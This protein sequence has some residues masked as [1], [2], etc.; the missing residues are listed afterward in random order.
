MGRPLRIRIH[1]G[2]YVLQ[3]MFNLIDRFAEQQV[4][5]NVAFQLFCSY[6][7]IKKWHAPDHTKIEAFRSRLSL[8]TQSVLLI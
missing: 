5:D 7:F 6:G 2:V 8:E 3:Q 4:R 1:L